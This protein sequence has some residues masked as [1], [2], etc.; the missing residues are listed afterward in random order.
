MFNNYPM[1]NI[2]DLTEL[3]QILSLKKGNSNFIYLY[4]I[5]H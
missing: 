2:F 5:V 4:I 1:L 3:Q